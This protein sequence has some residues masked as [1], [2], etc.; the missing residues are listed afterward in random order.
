MGPEGF[1]ATSSN[2]TNGRFLLLA[3]A[4][5]RPRAETNATAVQ[6]RID[7]TARMISVAATETRCSLNGYEGKREEEQPGQGTADP[8]VFLL[9]PLLL[10][11]GIVTSSPSL[12]HPAVWLV[13]IPVA[14]VWSMSTPTARTGRHI[15]EGISS[16]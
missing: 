3:L 1:L 2:R 4:K 9:I 5:T 7:P 10:C 8:L 15:E 6:S 12:I 11:I 13:G 16:C 14:S